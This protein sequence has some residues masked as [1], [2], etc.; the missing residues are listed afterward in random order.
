MPKQVIET[1]VGQ[2]V[3]ISVETEGDAPIPAPPAGTI[4]EVRAGGNDAAR[5]YARTSPQEEQRAQEQAR[6]EAAMRA[7][8]QNDLVSQ[9]TWYG[10]HIFRNRRIIVQQ[11]GALEVFDLGMRIGVG[12]TYETIDLAST[13]DDAIKG[14]RL[15]ALLAN[16]PLSKSQPLPNTSEYGK[17]VLSRDEATGAYSLVAPVTQFYF[18]FD[19]AAS[20]LDLKITK[21]ASYDAVAVALPTLTP[22][23]KIRAFLIPMVCMWVPS[24]RTW[25]HYSARY[26]RIGANGAE[27]PPYTFEGDYPDVNIANNPSTSA[28]VR[29]LY[30]RLPD[31]ANVIM[32][33]NKILATRAYA[34]TL[35]TRI[36]DEGPLALPDWSAITPLIDFRYAPVRMYIRENGVDH[37]YESSDLISFNGELDSSELTVSYL[38]RDTGQLTVLYR[39]G[40]IAGELTAILQIG[41]ETYYLWHKTNANDYV[42]ALAADRRRMIP[43]TPQRQASFRTTPV[44][45]PAIDDL[46]QVT[47]IPLSIPAQQL[48]PHGLYTGDDTSAEYVIDSYTQAQTF[49]DESGYEA[50]PYEYQQEPYQP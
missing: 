42:G 11:S 7:R 43:E 35:T 18:G 16:D 33:G 22:R 34:R 41:G 10:A 14:A 31:V 13:T 27:R 46:N 40:R 21:L 5:V 6:V 39:T 28:P 15:D 8:R 44:L 19:T 9:N 23:S 12:G 48:A 49:N 36:V 25:H 1:R 38:A 37:K 32:R 17:V 29:R 26:H 50:P 2:R 3:K 47:T 20:T 24:F 4:M 30:D 45:L